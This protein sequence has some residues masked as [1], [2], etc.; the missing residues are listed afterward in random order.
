[1]SHKLG[2]PYIIE[3]CFVAFKYSKTTSQCF[4][5]RT[6]YWLNNFCSIAF[7][8]QTHLKKDKHKTKDHLQRLLYEILEDLVMKEPGN[9]LDVYSLRKRK[10]RED[11]KTVFKYLK[12]CNG[13]QIENFILCCSE[14]ECLKL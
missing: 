4:H 8:S 3:E 5:N 11:T 10:L 6:L 7:C 14:T 13:D 2:R 1:M 9:V 12:E